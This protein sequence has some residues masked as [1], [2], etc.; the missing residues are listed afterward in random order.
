M[1]FS[2]IAAVVC[3]YACV[4]TATASSSIG[5]DI[6]PRVGYVQVF[7]AHKISADKIRS[8]LGIK[9]G[10]LLPTHEEAEHKIDALSG[11][12]ASSVR[13]VCC[14][15]RRMVLYVGIEEKNAPH[16]EFHAAPTADLSLPQEIADDYESLLN[17]VSLSIRAGN[18]DEDLTNGYSLMADPDSRKAQ[19]QLIPLVETNLSVVDQV[20][21]TS[22]DPDQRAAAAYVLQYGPRTARADK[23]VADDL[24]YALQDPDSDVRRN[25]MLS[26]KAV[27]VGNR[28][29]PDPEMHIEATWFVEL[30]NS[31]FW[32]DRR[33]ASAALVTLTDNRDA[34]TLA[35][36]RERALNSVIEMARWRDLEHALPGFVLAGRLAGLDDSAIRQAWLSGDR[37]AVLK[38]AAKKR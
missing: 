5:E 6:T 9:A 3:L 12:V 38:A 31:V 26:L 17:A 14:D 35:L 2:G 7:G 30:M 16:L 24:Q 18:A 8:S 33:N 19:Q 28:L 25:A 20:L 11:V 21:R 27:M 32:D 10:D 13:A 36:I 1:K 22:R 15:N 34:A 4:W 23:I 29:H 37:E